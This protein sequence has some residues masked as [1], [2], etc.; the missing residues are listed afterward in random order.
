M[1]TKLTEIAN[2]FD[3]L[4]LPEL[5]EL[6]QILKTVIEKKRKQDVEQKIAEIHSMAAAIGMVVELRSPE[7]KRKKVLAK[8]VNFD[9]PEEIWSGR[10]TEP[11]WLTEKL[12]EGYT[13]EDFLTK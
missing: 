10:G 9:N 4:S 11:R 2:K 3:N 5:T 1:S 6:L 13:K 7:D 8:Y 12:K